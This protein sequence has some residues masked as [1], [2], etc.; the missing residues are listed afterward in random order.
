MSGLDPEIRLLANSVVDRVYR[1][2]RRELSSGGLA[3][4]R[5]VGIGADG[6]PTRYIDKVAEESALRAI[7]EADLGVNVVSEEIGFVDMGGD[8][9]FVL[10]PVD[11][12]RNLVR[13][14]PF[15][16]VSLAVGKK[17]LSDVCFG[18]VR[19][20]FSGTRF[21]AEKGV[22]SFMNKKR[23]V[24]PEVPESERVFAVRL[25]GDST[26][27]ALE[28][29]TR[30]KI[31]SLGASS[32]ELCLVAS[33]ALDVFYWGGESMRVIDIAAGVL[34]VREAGGVVVDV[35]GDELD[36]ELSLDVRSSVVAGCGRGVIDEI[37]GL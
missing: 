13:G 26:S 2:I 31:R 36:M 1:R 14:I 5:M 15:S 10:D 6:T 3:L 23:L 12:T 16:A 24:V 21:V 11:G 37:L 8:V 28:V 29:A 35:R 25:G 9:T 33:N 18:V 22:G 30:D 17:S 27:S 34:I 19:D 20:V 4:G 7:R 32:L